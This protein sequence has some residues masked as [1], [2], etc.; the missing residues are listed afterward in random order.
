VDPALLAD[1]HRILSSHLLDVD[2]Y[3]IHPGD[4]SWWLYHHDPRLPP[5]ETRILGD[6]VAV[7]E[8]DAVEIDV[9]GGESRIGLL[10]AWTRKRHPTVGWVATADRDLTEALQARGLHP[11]GDATITFTR[12]VSPTGAAAPAGYTVR[13][14]GGEEE[15]PSRRAA[16]HAAFASTMDPPAHL[17]RYLAFMRSPVYDR[18]RDL[19]AVAPGGTVA[20]FLIWWPDAVTGIAQLEPVGTHPDHQGRGLGAAVF[21][22]ALADMR[23]AGMRVVRVCTDESRT[24]AVAFYQRLGFI[25]ADRL[26]WWRAADR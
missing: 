3:T 15:A 11:E 17:E 12:D 18:G 19:V 8:P 24:G 20:S 22:R 10:D 6:A 1:M 9:F 4:L 25:P 23:S 21:S 16:S 26:R 7:F 5:L 13:S 2:R 14:L